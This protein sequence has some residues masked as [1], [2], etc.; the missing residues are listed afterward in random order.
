[1]SPCSLLAGNASEVLEYDS[2][3]VEAL[4]LF[5][6]S[7]PGG[8]FVSTGD[9]GDTADR[10]QKGQ[11]PCLHTGCVD[12]ATLCSRRMAAHTVK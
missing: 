6:T 8:S 2:A 3:V 11:L 12:G 4:H 7:T 10:A 9:A 5:L 1:M